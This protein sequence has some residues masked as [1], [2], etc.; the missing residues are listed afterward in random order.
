M[1]NVP[2]EGCN[3]IVTVRSMP[4]DACLILWWKEVFESGRTGKRTVNRETTCHGLL[5]KDKL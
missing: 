1:W 4:W 5:V 3:V 2:G